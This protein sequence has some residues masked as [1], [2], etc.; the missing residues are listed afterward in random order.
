MK[1]YNSVQVNGAYSLMQN[2][3]AIAIT[4]LNKTY[5]NGFKALNDINLEIKRGEIFALLGPNYADQD[6]M[7]HRAPK[8][9]HHYGLGLR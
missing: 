1:Q 6:G 8:Q 3:T 9:R 2:N 4:A 7:R 5:S